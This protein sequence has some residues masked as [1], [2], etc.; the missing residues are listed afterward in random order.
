MGM[1]RDER[2]ADKALQ[3][4]HDREKAALKRGDERQTRISRRLEDRANLAKRE[5]R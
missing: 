3:R 5:G 4:H 1:G 2:R